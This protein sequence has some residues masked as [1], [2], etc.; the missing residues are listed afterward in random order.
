MRTLI[1]SG[2][3]KEGDNG[4]NYDALYIDNTCITQELSEEINEKQVSVRYWISK[5]EINS[6]EQAQE[7]FFKT[8]VGIAESEYEVAYSDATGYLWTIENLQIGGHHL[9]SELRG[10]A[11][12]YILLEIDIHD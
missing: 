9:D 5:T 8:L 4:D 7:S 6:K 3:I 12:K 1:Y 2:L 11:G 10:N